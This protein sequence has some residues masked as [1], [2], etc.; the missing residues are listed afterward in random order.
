MMAPILEEVKKEYA[1]IIQVDFVDAW[2]N[3]NEAR[4]Y[5]VRGIP[6]Q[7]FYDASGKERGRH[8]GFLSKE[9]ILKGFEQL[10]IPIKKPPRK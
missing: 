5:G 2:K 4:K 10:G 8:M 1:G 6:T 7:I 9:G 3:P